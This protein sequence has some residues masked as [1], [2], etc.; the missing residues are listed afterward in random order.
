MILIVLVKPDPCRQPDIT[1]KGSPIL[2]KPCSMAQK[3]LKLTRLV[4]SDCQSKVGS[5]KHGT[6]S[7]IIRNTF[8]SQWNTLAE[9]GDIILYPF[10]HGKFRAIYSWQFGIQ[11][12]LGQKDAPP[13]SRKIN[14]TLD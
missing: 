12:H 1:T 13:G 5:S 6:R 11:V 2:T 14:F 8:M 4:T 7:A 10:L 3:M 9:K